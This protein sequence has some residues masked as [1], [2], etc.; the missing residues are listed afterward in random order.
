MSDERSRVEV[1]GSGTRC[2]SCGE[3]L[4]R[5]MYRG[6]EIMMHPRGYCPGASH[7]REQE[8]REDEGYQEESDDER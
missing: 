4:E 1:L 2:E 7:E 8:Q 3:Q 6:R 5:G